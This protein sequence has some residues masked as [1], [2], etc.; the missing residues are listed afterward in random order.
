MQSSWPYVKS[1]FTAEAAAAIIIHWK[2]PQSVI[3]TPSN[4]ANRS[5]DLT[6]GFRNKGDVSVICLSCRPS[7]A[8][9]CSWLLLYTPFPAASSLLRSHLLWHGSVATSS[10]LCRYL[11]KR[12][13]K[14][15]VEYSVL[16]NAAFADL[17]FLLSSL[18]RSESMSGTSS[19]T[20]SC[21]SK[22]KMIPN[23][24]KP[25]ASLKWADSEASQIQHAIV[26]RLIN[27]NE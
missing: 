12:P 11:S 15:L 3:V 26:C 21:S 22:C 25:A 13:L 23:G 16:T 24:S 6:K 17:P 7:S 19:G 27:T 9:I 2:E 14:T 1:V 8:S 18:K 5:I 20:C 10:M 4:W